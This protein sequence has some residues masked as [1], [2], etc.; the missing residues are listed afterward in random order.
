[1]VSPSLACS[2]LTH[3]HSSEPTPRSQMLSET[4]CLS[5]TQEAFLTSRLPLPAT[6][7][8]QKDGKGPALAPLGAATPLQR[9][10]WTRSHCHRAFTAPPPHP[11]PTETAAIRGRAHLQ[12]NLG[13]AYLPVIVGAQHS[14]GHALTCPPQVILGDAREN[15]WPCR[16]EGHLVS[17]PRLGSGALAPALHL[18]EW[19]Q[20]GPASPD[21]H[22]SP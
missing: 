15:G 22:S 5:T 12:K 6:A 13:F 7:A 9:P 20:P 16:W 4:H 14:L 17:L 8:G 21:P 10:P 2:L 11:H 18:T 1:M 3:G 19:P